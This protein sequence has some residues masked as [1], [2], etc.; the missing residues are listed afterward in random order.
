MLTSS[1][2]RSR[3]PLSALLMGLLALTLTPSDGAAQQE[4]PWVSMTLEE[5]LS[6]AIKVSP[7][8]VQ[9]Q[10]TVR[11]TTAAEKT[12]FGAYLPDL[13]FNANSSLSSSQ[14]LIP[15]TG[16]TVTGSSD[17]YSAGLS[18]SWDV[19]TGFRRRSERQRAQA[20]SQSAQ[21]TL[22]GQRF[23]VELSVERAFF[24]ALRAEELITVAKS[25]IERAQEGVGFA[26]RRL[27]VGSATRSDLLRAQLELNTAREALLQQEN[28][29][30]T[31][32]LS[33]GR[34]VG[35]DGPVDPAP[36]GP[37]DPAPL[38]ASREEV[39]ATLVAQAPSVRAAEAAVTA[40]EASIG[41]A[42]SQYYPSVRLSAGYDW[43]YQDRGRTSWS[44]RLGLSYPIFDGFARDESMVRARTQAEV[45]QAQLS[46]TRRSVRAEAERVLSQLQLVEERLT[47]NRQAVE[48]AQEDLRVQQERYRLGATTIL[49][50]LTSQT[51][52]VE[53]QNNLVGLRF[54]YV[55]ARAELQSIV[56][57]EL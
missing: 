20:D 6:R 29:R 30:L 1:W 50:L 3:A 54:D 46:D 31:A 51:A 41:T 27:A 37:I 5:A 15:E 14:R 48:V 44:V 55:L 43:F 7:Q 23:V 22:A 10:G 39:V 4:A 26:E 42:R 33:L 17:S 49:E 21:A 12:A 56:G 25:R 11:T 18:T 13:S 57:R 2:N 53:A 36:S 52:L 34:L 45:A 24:D 28:Q 40:A 16:A 9:A 35:V 8:I 32:A 38:K 19:F 47:L